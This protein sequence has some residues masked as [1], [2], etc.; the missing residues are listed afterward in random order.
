M[1]D[2]SRLYAKLTLDFADSPKIAPLSDK[3]FRQYIE[4][5]LWS[6][7]IM[8]D[9][10]I[11]ERMIHKLI[12][13]DSLAELTG[14]DPVNPS[15][16]VAEGGYQIHDFGKHQNTREKIDKKREAGRLGGLAKARNSGSVASAREPLKQNSSG[17]LAIQIT[18]KDIDVDIDINTLKP[19]KPVK[20]ASRLPSPFYVTT[21]MRA[22]AV[23]SV[24]GLDVDLTTEE[25]CDY[26]RGAPNGVKLDW[27][28]TWRNWL[29]NAYKK[30][31]QVKYAKP[32]I[33]QPP[34]KEQLEATLCKIHK[35]YPLPCDRC[36]EGE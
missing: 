34:T 32:A 22:W 7:R 30:T 5:L 24:P 29:R 14:N 23:K 10:Y 15:I 11:P 28:A 9:G 20:R 4:T 1:T 16:A 2:D 8:T 31:P 36:K 17:P 21:E 6:T 27:I 35:G 25:F 26:W 13:S 12:D 3:A 18:D 33:P 19:S